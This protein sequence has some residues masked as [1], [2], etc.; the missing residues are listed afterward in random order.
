MAELHVLGHSSRAKM[1]SL[2]LRRILGPQWPLE[3]LLFPAFWP[4]NIYQCKSTINH[5]DP[6]YY[7]SMRRGQC[8][9]I[10]GAHL[11]QIRS[12]FNIVQKAFDP[13]LVNCPTRWSLLFIFVFLCWS[14]PW[15]PKKVKM[16]SPKKVFP[17]IHYGM[18][19]LQKNWVKTVIPAF[20]SGQNNLPPS[21]WGPSRQLDDQHRNTNMNDEDHLVGQLT[22][23]T[24][25]I[26]KM[27]IDL[28]HFCHWQLPYR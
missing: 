2:N 8:M 22:T 12:F 17:R 14:S 13:P 16:R 10:R 4:Q 18:Y 26:R 23:P 27:S 11:H 3:Y 24:P 15:P 7:I 28:R 25:T 9:N 19:I 21:I 20:S 1:L 6:A 5:T